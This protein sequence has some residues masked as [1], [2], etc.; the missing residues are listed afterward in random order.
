[1]SD[2]R[3][4]MESSFHALLL[5]DVS[6]IYTH[7]L[8][9]TPNLRVGLQLEHEGGLHVPEDVEHCTNS[10]PVEPGLIS[11]LFDTMRSREML[12]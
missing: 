4:A 5:G 9:H 12:H 7:N 6:G 8:S 11:G 2:I 1:M 10:I 3:G